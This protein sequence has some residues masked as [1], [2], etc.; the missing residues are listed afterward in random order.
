MHFTFSPSTDANH[1]L[2]VISLLS[3]KYAFLVSV[4]ATFPAF[5]TAL[6]PF[7]PPT[8]IPARTAFLDTFFATA[9]PPATAPLIP[10]VIAFEAASSTYSISSK[11]ISFIL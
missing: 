1:S 6:P 10:S 11:N 2:E 8:L 9:F 7:F 5:L 4:A 3:S